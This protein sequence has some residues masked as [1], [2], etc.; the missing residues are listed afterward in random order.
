MVLKLYGNSESP[1]ARLVASILL[2]KEVPFELVDL[3]WNETT[4][5]KYLHLQPFGQM[6]CIVSETNPCPSPSC[7]TMNIMSYSLIAVMYRTMMDLFST[8]AKRS[9]IISHPSIQTKEPHQFQPNLKPTHSSI[10]QYQQRSVTLVFMLK[11]SYLR[12]FTDRKFF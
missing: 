10:K 9:A 2:E 7:R 5:P 11:R 4:S 1:N 8:K 6:P 3:G 12:T